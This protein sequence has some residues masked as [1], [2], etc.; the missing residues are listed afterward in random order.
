MDVGSFNRREPD[1]ITELLQNEGTAHEMS[2][3]TFVGFLCCDENDCG[4]YVAVSGK[5]SSESH[6]FDDPYTGEMTD[7]VVS[8]YLPEAMIPAPQIIP[9]PDNLNSDSK[10]H[11]SRA[12]ALFWSDHAS[13]ANRLRIVVEY[14]LDQLSIPR[15]G[16]KGQR[17][18][19]RLDLAD[20]IDLLKTA[21]P[22]HDGALNALRFVGNVGSHEGVVDFE[23]L[24]TCFEVLED[25]MIEL[26][27][28]RRDKLNQRIQE[29]NSRK[30]KPKP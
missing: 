19:A 24:L 9:Y 3:G 18:N 15:V 16:Q 14:L 2:S 7:H 28:G 22:G 8:E 1:Y 20:R 5:Y 13:C 25:I 4:E 12:F 29:I 27:E 17:K 6:L 23:D 21:K 26:I 10:A 30:G 11:L